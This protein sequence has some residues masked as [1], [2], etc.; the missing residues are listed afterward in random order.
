MPLAVHLPSGRRAA[1]AAG[2]L[3]TTGT[4]IT[5]Q[6]RLISSL[7]SRYTNEDHALL[8]LAATDWWR[9]RMREPTFYGQPYG[10]T[11]ESI[12]TG[13][14]HV[15]GVSYNFALPITLLVLAVS[16]WWFLAW[17]AWKRGWILPA[18]FALTAPIILSIDHWIVVGVIGTGVGR[19][20]AALAG[21]LCLGARPTPRVIGAAVGLA[22]F[23]VAIDT[24]SALIAAPVMVW[25]AWDWLRVK[26]VWLPILL[27]ALVPIAWFA[28]NAWFNG[29]FPDHALHAGP[30]F[31]PEWGVLVDNFGR[32]DRLFGPHVAE[33]Y[34]HGNLIPWLCSLALV[35][36]LAS[37]SWRASGATACY[38]ALLVLLATLPKSRDT[39]DS[40]WFPAARMT[41]AAPMGLWFVCAV[42]ASA[43]AARLAPQLRRRVAWRVLAAL[44]ILCV[45]TATWRGIMWDERIGPIERAGLAENRLPLRTIKEIEDICR[46]AA[47]AADEAKTRIVIFPEDRA[48]NY[49]CPALYPRLIT[50]YPGYERRYW[51]LRR[52][53][54]RPSDRM[55]I[56]GVPRKSCRR[57]LWKNNVAAC[58]AVANDQALR[59]DFPPK[60][61][62]DVLHQ[63]GY[64]PRP[65]GPDCRPNDRQ[66]CVWWASK[67]GS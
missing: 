1:L 39:M 54:S 22:G 60:P 67:Y 30:G 25:A 27:G 15:L 23:S 56:W 48:A 17:G 58:S 20:L 61:P 21:A 28:L 40:L 50:A 36:G 57:K 5:E 46:S 10:V 12:P 53:A 65:F 34:Q 47:D 14:L 3:I 64:S 24:A 7:L 4:I 45:G 49:A 37:R 55:L 6:T 11:F 13:L 29:K 9:L 51:I 26:R 66:T 42:T 33:L 38:I 19:F 18:L 35:A 2:L 44:A 52:L 59:V 62:L 32:M 8:W 41:L 31:T 63:L 16:A 43:I